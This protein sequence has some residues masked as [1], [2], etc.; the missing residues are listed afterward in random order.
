MSDLSKFLKRQEK[1]VRG[2]YDKNLGDFVEKWKRPVTGAALG[3]GAG[4]AASMLGPAGVAAAPYLMAGL[5][6]GG[7]AAG[8]QRTQDQEDKWAAA[9]SVEEQ[10]RAKHQAGD[11]LTGIIEPYLPPE[12]GDPDEIYTPPVQPNQPPVATDPVTGMPVI[13][14]SMGNI[15]TGGAE[16]GV[17]SILD[18]TERARQYQLDLINQQSGDKE[19]ARAEMAEILN[20]QMERQFSDQVPAY[21]E[22]LN[23]RGLLRSSALGDRL[24]TERSK[25]AAGV[26]EQLALQGIQDKYGSIDALTGVGDQYLQGR[27]SALGRKFSL[28]DWARQMQASKE[29]GQAVTPIQPYTGG[30]KSGSTQAGMAGAGLG[31]QAAGLG[32]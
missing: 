28:E 11:R 31:L 4:A 30:G 3:L 23:T 18:E 25:M 10:E 22:D 2:L 32:K 29:L 26:N 14:P 27:Q 13:D 9:K 5:G 21:L 12:E 20:Q 15:P 16:T 8:Y 6:A 7:A 24:S 19:Q 1:N 17:G